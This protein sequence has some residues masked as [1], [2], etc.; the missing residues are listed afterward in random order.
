MLNVCLAI[1]TFPN[2]CDSKSLQL[3]YSFIVLFVWEKFLDYM[4]DTE[5][6]S[7]I[8]RRD[9]SYEDE[10]RIQCSSN[11]IYSLFPKLLPCIPERYVLATLLCSGLAVAYMLRVNLS[12]A[13]VE[14]VNHTVTTGKGPDANVTYKVSLNYFL[15]T[16]RC[17]CY[18]GSKSTHK[19]TIDR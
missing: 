10:D 13:L 15:H 8:K 7:L 11:C 3:G 14:M 5:K 9:I 17:F 6:E 4:V 1:N 19:Q 18:F 2:R 16:F 12:I